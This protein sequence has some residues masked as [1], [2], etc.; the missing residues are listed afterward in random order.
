MQ[1]RCPHRGASGGGEHAADGAIVGDRGGSGGQ[2]PEAVA[3]VVVA[4][5]VG[6]GR[7]SVVGVLD[8]VEARFI[9][10]PHLDAGLWDR[11]AINVFDRSLHPA[12][13]TDRPSGEVVAVVDA[14]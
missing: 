5:Q 4:E 12:R 10:F 9:G 8:V 1:M 11:L 3:A 6:S 13:L 7:H 2:S 14:W